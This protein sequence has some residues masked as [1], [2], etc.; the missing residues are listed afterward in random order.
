MG[1]ISRGILESTNDEQGVQLVQASFLA[2]E[3][4]SDLERLQNYGLTSNPPDGCELLGVFVGGNNENGFIVSC[5]HRETRL[6]SLAK[7][8][9][10]LWT[11]ESGHK[12]VLKRGGKFQIKNQQF[13]LVKVENELI[14]SLTD[15]FVN[16]MLGPQKILN[17]TNPLPVIKLKHDTFVSED[18]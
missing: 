16:T 1:L 12:L 9:V 14:Q 15:G 7:G 10:A 4:R 11:D 17:P 6:K 18:S 3:V 8:E 2:D 13:D 5:D